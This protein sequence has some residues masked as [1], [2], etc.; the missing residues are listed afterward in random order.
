MVGA[1]LIIDALG[2]VRLAYLGEFGVLII[3]L[4]V[5]QYL[6]LYLIGGRQKREYEDIVL[7]AERGES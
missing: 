1:I 4:G 2:A 6:K 7:N 3:P 5:I